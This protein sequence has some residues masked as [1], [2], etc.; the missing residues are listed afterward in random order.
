MWP[1]IPVC[2]PTPPAAGAA[3]DEDAT[4]NARA[5]RGCEERL[6]HR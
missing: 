6:P 4:R 5:G 1:G 3:G 2:T